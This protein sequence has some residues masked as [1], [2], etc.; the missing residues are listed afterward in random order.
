MRALLKFELLQLLRD[1]KTI[2][3][4]FILPMILY[5]IINGGL[6]FLTKSQVEKIENEEITILLDNSFKENKLFNLDSLKAKS[7][8]S[9]YAKIDTSQVDSL[10]DNYSAILTLNSEEV[11]HEIILPL[12]AFLSSE[13]HSTDLIQTSEGR[14][15]VPCYN[16]D[17][18]IIWGAT[19]MMIAELEALLKR[20]C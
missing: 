2:I 11:E 14:M 13:N 17:E 16:V 15:E 7:I 20:H 9:E 10:L 3:F 4:V 6:N 12:K 1:K 19:S 5:P 8:I 18:H